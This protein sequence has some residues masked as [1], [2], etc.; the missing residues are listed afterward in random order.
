MQKK[1]AMP[2]LE[3]QSTAGHASISTVA[4]SFGAVIAVAVIVYVL[5]PK[6]QSLTP[7]PFS[8]PSST[9]GIG[10]ASSDPL[11]QPP[12][13][14]VPLT[15]AS[16]DLLLDGLDRAAKSKDVD[17]V[18]R[19]LALDAAILIHMKQGAQQQTATLTRE[20]Y[21]KALAAEFAFPSAND[22]ARVN[23]AVILAPDE[24]S[25]K[26]SF[27]STETLRQ[28]NREFKVEGEQTLIVKMRGDK[29]MIV[30]LEK[31]VPGD[32]T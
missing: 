6:L 8:S 2:E 16:I 15:R 10:T 7:Q 14:D 26:I 25:A 24:R 18:L 9:A 29:P 11:P 31:F 22:F 13:P 32:S 19:H 27:K 20:D 12:K 28:A 3:R 5:W 4:M 23:T 17:G 1:D 21:R 30:S